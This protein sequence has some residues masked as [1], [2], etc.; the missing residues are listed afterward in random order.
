MPNQDLRA[1]KDAVAKREG[2]SVYR[3][4]A[5]Q[6]TKFID[7]GR[8]QEIYLDSGRLINAARLNANIKDET[9]LQKLHLTSDF[10]EMVHSIG[11]R[12]TS[13]KTDSV[14]DFAMIHYGHTDP[15]V[16]GTHAHVQIV[17][18]GV[19]QLLMLDEVD[20][21]SDDKEIGQFAITF[22]DDEDF[23]NIS[24]RFYLQ[25]G[26]H[27]PAEEP[28]EV[29]DT[30]S[31]DYKKMISTSLIQ[32]GN[33]YRIQKAIAKAK[34][35]EDVTIA[36]LGG[37]ITQ[38]AGAVPINTEC[39]AYQSYL[40]FCDM[41]AKDKNR[42]HYV[43]AGAGGTCSELGLVRYKSDVTDGG[44]INPDVVIVE[45]AVNDEGDETKGDCYEGLVRKIWNSPCKPAVILLFSVFADG[46]N[47][48][49]RFIPMGTKCS[50]PM[51][52][53]KN[54]VCPQFDKSEKDGRVVSR[55]LYFYDMFH[56]SNDGHRIM[57]DCLI[58]YFDCA[59]KTA[60]VQGMDELPVC[61]TDEFESV[62]YFGIK[63]INHN[64]K[65]FDAGDFTQTD[66]DLQCVERNLDRARSPMFPENWK[67]SGNGVNVKPLKFTVSCRLLMIVMK[68]SASAASARAEVFVDGRL[69]RTL[70]PREIGW[71]HCSALV[72]IREQTEA[73]HDVEVRIESN[74]TDTNEFTILG[75]AKV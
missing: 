29:L 74:G 9:M 22:P 25:D 48:Q 46:S 30:K 62:Q 3:K 65:N 34:A 49:D 50:L 17:A 41:F 63:D 37:S 15:Y 33:T 24:V 10:K 71:T 73:E 72:L 51:I 54:A 66:S 57:A 67:Y 1:P 2:V 32:A 8:R 52:S 20:W 68:D 7:G 19:E 70:N 44:K 45:F 6:A 60:P 13:K 35:G 23:A 75:F 14:F 36:Y 39:Y 11:I 58:N 40:G 18:N 42:M 26:Y 53:V 27:A 55:Q 56:P 12:I 64:V 47:L 21:S 28:D 5:I 43:K 16:S 38:G 31:S 59:S 4:L 69:C 61:R